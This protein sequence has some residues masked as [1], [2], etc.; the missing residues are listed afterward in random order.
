MAIEKKIN[1]Y[2]YIK[3]Q[4]NWTELLVFIFYICMQLG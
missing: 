1:I 2:I 4:Q 3:A